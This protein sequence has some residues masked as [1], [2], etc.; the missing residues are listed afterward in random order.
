MPGLSPC[1][2]PA[3]GTL[4]RRFRRDSLFCPDELDSL[5]SYFDTGASGAGP[6]SKCGQAVRCPLLPLELGLNGGV[7]MQVP[8]ALW[9]GVSV[10]P[11]CRTLQP[12]CCPLWA[13]MGWGPKW[14]PLASMGVPRGLPGGAGTPIC[15][16]LSLLL[17]V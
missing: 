4:E 12:A 10:Q 6:R 17:Q 13:G 9:R 3:A 5:F 11:L 8:L 14:G 7:R 16:S 1:S 2:I 15:S